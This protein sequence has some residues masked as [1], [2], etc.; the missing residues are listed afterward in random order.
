MK[1]DASPELAARLMV[2]V[3]RTVAAL[4]DLVSTSAMMMFGMLARRCES[5]QRPCMNS[6]CGP[7]P[8]VVMHV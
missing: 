1:S 6:S 8:A 5:T 3:A 2:A 7:A 4:H